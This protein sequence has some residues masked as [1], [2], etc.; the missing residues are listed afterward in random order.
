MLAK[1]L[2]D[3]ALTLVAEARAA[4]KFTTLAPCSNPTTQGETC[5]MTFINSFGAKAYRRALS[6]E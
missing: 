6:D 5:A 1:A 2:D 4:G 3:A